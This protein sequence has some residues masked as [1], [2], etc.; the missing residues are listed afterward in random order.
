MSD[1]SLTYRTSGVDR[2]AVAAG[3]D[4]VQE[5]IRG[6]FT[7]HVL[8]DIGHFAGLF[9]LAGSA[10]RVL[11]S[12]MDGVGPK[13]MLPRQA[14]RMDVVGRDAITHGVSDVAVLGAVPLF[15]LDYVAAS[16]LE[17]ADLAAVVS[18]MAAACREEGAAL[19]GGETSQMPGV[20]TDAGLDVVACVIGAAER[21]AL[22]DGSTIRP[23]DAVIGLASNGLHTN[24]Y[25]LV[26]AV[27]RPGGR[28][29]PPGFSDPGGTLADALLRP[30][31]SYR[32]ALQALAG[33]GWLR[34]AAHITG[35]GLPGNLVR[36]LPPARRARIDTTAWPVP[37][38]FTIL[39]RGGRIPRG[40]MFA[41]FNIGVGLA[42]VG[43]PHPA[44]PAGGIF[45]AKR[46]DG[47]DL[48]ESAPGAPGLE[49]PL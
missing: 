49:L 18:G 44:R 35:G 22:C 6:T 48:R 46:A 12:P 34:G 40:E 16:Q 32:R 45:W 36:I 20:Y 27:M 10:D 19:L 2:G 1:G 41:T 24:G 9:R 30:H 39:A 33:T 31:R 3:L 26:R 4:A 38:I 47:W 15:A 28:T 43:P 13:V 5:R 8:G 17:P 37:P 7:T 11:V 42:V 14:G 21:A 29:L 23:G 25:T